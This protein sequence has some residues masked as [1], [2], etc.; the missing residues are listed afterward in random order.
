MMTE[1][2]HKAIIKNM[3]EKIKEVQSNPEKAKE[4]IMN[5]GLYTKS[6]NLKSKYK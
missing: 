2:E 3:K 6:G 1:K 5:C 4:V